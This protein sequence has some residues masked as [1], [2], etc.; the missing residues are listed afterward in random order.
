MS[1]FY[2][3]KD[4]KDIAK[5]KRVMEYCTMVPGFQEKIDK[6]PEG[7]LKEIGIDLTPKD[8]MLKRKATIND[9]NIQAVHPGTAAEKYANFMKK[10]FELRDRILKENTP[11]NERMK[12]WRD[13]QVARCVMALG[14]KSTAIVHS[15]MIFELSKG[16]SVGCEFCGLNAKNLT[17]VYKCTDENAK[18]FREICEISKEIIGDAAGCGTCYYATEPLDNPDYEKLIDIYYDVFNNL[19]QVTT[20][21]SIRNIERTRALVKKMTEIGTI[22]YRF[23]VLSLDILYKIFENFTPE[24][25]VLVELL[26]QFEEAPANMF[27]NAGRHGSENDEYGDTIACLSGFKVN[28]CEKTISLVT[29]TWADKDHPTG[30]IIIDTRSFETAEDFREVLTDMIKKDMKTLLGPNEKLKLYP[31]IKLEKSGNKTKILGNHG[32]ELTLKEKEMAKLYEILFPLL[33]GEYTRSEIAM[34]MMEL[35]QLKGAR[36]EYVVYIINQLWNQ[37][38]L[39]DDS[40]V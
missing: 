19:P 22:V 2:D 20:A 21:A 12:K 18:L 3:E 40:L 8:I 23:S 38:M 35:P 37:G 9:H 33:K 26:P 17:A 27:I 28:M 10:K 16:C 1:F 24:E 14:G 29:P 39:V 30:E 13:R 11:D 7:T 15:S 4:V 31:F 25:L 36:P 5:V 32:T 34:K 6:D